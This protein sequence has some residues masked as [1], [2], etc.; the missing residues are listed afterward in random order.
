MPIFATDGKM[1]ELLGF[2]FEAETWQIRCLIVD[3]GQWLAGKKVLIVADHLRAPKAREE[4]WHVDVARDQ[5]RNSPCLS[6]AESTGGESGKLSAIDYY[7]LEPSGEISLMGMKPGSAGIFDARGLHS[8][9]EVKGYAVHA[10]DGEIGNLIDFIFD[11]ESWI[12]R[13]LVMDTGDLWPGRKVLL[14]PEWIESVSWY[15]SK[16]FFTVTRE[17]VRTA[18]SCDLFKL[19][20]SD[21]EEKLFDHYR[22]PRYRI[23]SEALREPGFEGIGET[24]RR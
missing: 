14:S 20:D 11:D 23:P 12:I 1:G 17:R 16:V 3:T 9:D 10:I 18:P 15:D 21:C 4:R 7:I 2:L 19:P 6:K 22:M 8:T 5:I 13:Y 24:E